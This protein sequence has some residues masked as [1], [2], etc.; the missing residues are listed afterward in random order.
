[1]AALTIHGLVFTPGTQA[2]PDVSGNIPLEWLGGLRHDRKLYLDFSVGN[3]YATPRPWG[4]VSN[5]TVLRTNVQQ[6]V[7]DRVLLDEASGR[8]THWYHANTPSHPVVPNA[9]QPVGSPILM[10]QSK[11]REMGQTLNTTHMRF[12]SVLTASDT[13]GA[14]LDRMNSQ[15]QRTHFPQR[16]PGYVHVSSIR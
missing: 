15:P 13:T 9:G 11:L 4:A 12:G 6:L 2:Q 8:V 14:R 3:D 16:A 7:L 5:P 1:M 10:T